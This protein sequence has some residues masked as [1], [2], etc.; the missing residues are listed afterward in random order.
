[1]NVKKEK[2]FSDESYKKKIGLQLS[3]WRIE[4]GLSMEKLG[5]EIGVTDKTIKNIER[6]ICAPKAPLLDRILRFFNV[7]YEKFLTATHDEII[8]HLSQTK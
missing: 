8:E 6:G 7:T 4:K 1:M 5:Y 3:I 2:Y